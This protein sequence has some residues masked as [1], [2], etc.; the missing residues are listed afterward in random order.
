MLTL[1]QLLALSR[2]YGMVE[3]SLSRQIL[4]CTS[5][6][7]MQHS[8]NTMVLQS[9]ILGYDIPEVEPELYQ[10]LSFGPTDDDDAY[11][12]D[13][14][15]LQGASKI[16]V[17]GGFQVAELI[18]VGPIVVI[19]E[20]SEAREDD[21]VDIPASSER[22]N[23]RQAGICHKMKRLKADYENTIDMMSKKGTRTVS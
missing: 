16:K 2:L 23:C 12:D 4:E 15:I 7:L 8:S 5:T 21:F 1:L 9:Q 10:R 19:G 20:P 14:F 17:I 13:I 18:E 11:L 6:P 22:I 3:K